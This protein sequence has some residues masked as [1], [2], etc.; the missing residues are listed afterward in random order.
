[1]TLAPEHRASV[2]DDLS[3]S[4]YVRVLSAY[5][6]VPVL[7]CPYPCLSKS[8]SVCVSV[9]V[10]LCPYSCPCPSLSLSLSVSGPVY[11]RLFP[12]P[13]LPVS[14]TLSLSVCAPFPA[15][16]VPVF[17]TAR[18]CPCPCLHVPLSLS[19]C[20]PVLDHH[21][22]CP[23]VTP[24]LT[25]CVSFAVR[26]CG[27]STDNFKVTF[28]ANGQLSA[29]ITPGSLATDNFQ[30]LVRPNQEK[31]LVESNLPSSE[32]LNTRPIVHYEPGI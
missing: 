24:S 30:R 6:P 17:F 19:V 12:C 18:L 14:L 5:V 20:V 22:P 26:V 23:F 25:C 21:C 9:P 4:A 11:V 7:L 1:M 8:L 27:K 3:L 2:H 10:H 16:C 28:V 15:S 31:L 13:C 29:F 32:Y